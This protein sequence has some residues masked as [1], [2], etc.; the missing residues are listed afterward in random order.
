MRC[1][2]QIVPPLALSVAVALGSV[3][4]VSAQR[5]NF[6]RYGGFDGLPQ[7]Q[8]LALAQDADG[9]IWLGTY[10]GLS[11][12]NGRRFS[13]LTTQEGLCANAVR[14]ILAGP[15]G[16]LWIGTIG[17]GVCRV[18][19]GAVLETFREPDRLIDDY[20][21]DIE[22]SG[23]GAY[24]VATEKGITRIEGGRSLHYAGAQGLPPGG[25]WKIL[26]RADGSILAATD[27]GVYR[28]AGERF[29]FVTGLEGPKGRVRTLVETDGG[30]FAG[31]ERGLYEIRGERLRHIPLLPGRE[32]PLVYDMAPG[33]DGVLWLGTMDGLFAVE[34]GHVKHLTARNGIP[35]NPVYRILP[36]REGDLWFGTDEG[37]FKLVPGP[38]TVFRS[39]DGLPHTVVRALAVD[40]LD[41]VWFGTRDGL[42]VLRGESLKELANGRLLNRRIYALVGLPDG[43]VLAGTRR[44]LYLLAD[45]RARGS[46][47]REQGL[48]NEHVLCL[49]RGPDEGPVIVGTASGVVRWEAGRIAPVNAPAV[50]SARPLAMSYDRKGRLWLGLRAG[51]ALITDGSSVLARLGAREGLSDQTVWSLSP[52]G[53][54][55]MWIGTN[56]DGAFHV[57][58]SGK[59]DRWDVAR[60]LV[61]DFVWQVLRSSDGDVWFFTS[62]GLDRLRDGKLRHYGRGDGL[63]SL[64]GMAGAALEDHRGR[65]WFASTLGVM[66]YDPAHDRTVPVPPRVVLERAASSVYG[67][68][69]KGGRLSHSPGILTFELAV[70]T[71]RDERGIHFRHRLLP[72]EKEWSGPD[73]AGIV[74]FVGVRPGS[75]RLQALAEDASGRTSE[76]VAEFPFTVSPP[77]W[78]TPLAE[79]LE[80]LL[81]IAAIILFMRMRTRRLRRERLR[82]EG[83][84]AERTGELRA[85]A[86]EL[87][88]LATTDELTGT[89][90]RRRFTEVLQT[91]LQHLAR[92]PSEARLSIVVLD[93]DGFKKVNDTYG[94]EAGDRLLAAIGRQLKESLRVTDLV[95]RYGGD[96][97]AIILPMT[98]RDGAMRAASK[99]VETIAG[100]TVPAGGKRIGVTASAGVAVVASGANGTGQ[101]DQLIA[102]ADMGLYAAKRAGGNRVFSMDGTWY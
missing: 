7:S 72:V 9:F 10:G 38:F 91:E 69:P 94:H 73:A 6:Q 51:G 68:I 1:A 85:Q 76:L 102:H 21:Q 101:L 93:L 29:V 25:V 24:W 12:Y 16:D 15:D 4:A 84:V 63:L 99:L 80:C 3:T 46:W 59:I 58:G 28:L 64:E 57:T 26:R 67:V 22:P 77:L 71:Y 86:E 62:R 88:R 65:L 45:G 8:V 39:E 23:D 92:A 41:G 13:T 34:D 18:A 95:A 89:A 75:Y 82:L 32:Q 56:G 19:H 98:P 40:H 50:S 52:D 48:P 42:A 70:P 33:D 37:L 31:T 43:G 96:E 35:E 90:N 55:G 81:L 87:R 61:N 83:V 30:L 17:G 60:G 97:F 20:V 47:G 54:G 100:I 2:V 44:G 66:C 14:E 36:D 27:R 5:L 11:R 53:E 74:R 49:A 78:R 79:V